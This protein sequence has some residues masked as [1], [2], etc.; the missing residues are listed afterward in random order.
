MSTLGGQALFHAALLVRVQRAAPER[1]RPRDVRSPVR[2]AARRRTGPTGARHPCSPGWSA[3]V[4]LVALPNTSINSASYYSGLA[5]FLGLYQTLERLPDDLVREP[6]ARPCAGSCRSRSSAPRLCTLRQNYQAAVGVVLVVAYLCAFAALRRAKRAVDA[7]SSR[8]PS[9]LGLRRSLRR[10]VARPP[11]SLERHVPLPADEGNVPGRCGGA[12]PAHDADALRAVLRGRLAAARPD[13]DAAALHARRPVR[14]RAVAAAAAGARSGSRVSCR[15]RS[16]GVAFSLS[17]CGQ[18]RALRLRLRDGVRAPHVADGGGH[19]SAAS[20]RGPSP[21]RAPLALLIFALWRRLLD[22]ENR[23]RT[24]KMLDGAPPRHRRDAPPHRARAGRASDR[25]GYRRLQHAVPDG[26]R[27]LIMVDEPYF[28]DYA[29]QRDLESRHARNREPAARAF[30]ASR[31]PSRSRSTSA[32][33]AFATSPSW[34]RSARRIS[35]RREIWFD[36][37]YDPDEIWRVYAPYIVDVMDNLVALSATRKHLHEG[38]RHG[39]ARSRGETVT[40]RPL[41][42]GSARRRVPRALRPR[43]AD[44]QGRA[45]PHRR[46]RSRTPSTTRSSISRSPSR[47]RS[48]AST[49]S[50][51]TSS[52]R[53]R[54]PSAGRCS[55]RSRSRSPA[56]RR[57][58]RSR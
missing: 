56:P 12:E 41:A 8:A 35:Y 33:T 54:R 11:L 44:V 37:L 23:V 27:I 39:R 22:A 7:S 45:P 17:D 25:R 9:C 50:C 3:I 15:S 4:F 38:S 19:A 58:C 20:A 48:V 46:R 13:P 16:L 51:P 6:R 21:G 43:R 24:K 49:A 32:R 52:R 55:S 1:V 53:L 47:S 28:F 10:A 29:A 14:A 31:A 18:P 30:R 34:S 36:H 40:S 26:A 2:W 5:F 42:T 57:G